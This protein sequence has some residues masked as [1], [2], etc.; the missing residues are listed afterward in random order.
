MA[1][2][3]LDRMASD[4]QKVL[5]EYADEVKDNV[6]SITRQM[7]QKGAKALKASSKA[8]FGG[9]GKYAS[10]WTYQTEKTRFGNTTTIY[11]RTPGLPHLLE[12]GHAKRGGGRV[13]GRKHIAPVEA[14]LTR[15]F[16]MEVK[17]KL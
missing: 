9:T 10:G 11:N 5:K 1:T 15:T 16:E 2:T 6:D 3:P 4:I 8:S 13:A 17:A 14:E 12:N 7:G